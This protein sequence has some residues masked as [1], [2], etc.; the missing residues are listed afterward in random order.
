MKGHNFLPLAVSLVFLSGCQQLNEGV[1]KV[2]GAIS[3]S[4]SSL[5]NTLG[6]GR[7]RSGQ[8]SSDAHYW[9]WCCLQRL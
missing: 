1:N 5:N 4:L 9:P 6:G 2:N 8:W 7:F 3:S